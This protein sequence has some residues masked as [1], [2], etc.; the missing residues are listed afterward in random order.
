MGQVNFKVTVPQAKVCS[1]VEL[2]LGSGLGLDSSLAEVH[3]KTESGLK[4]T[5][6]VTP[7]FSFPPD[8]GLGILTMA[9][10]LT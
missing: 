3:L 8:L 1:L 4:D 10:I 6:D 9:L 5:N 7:Q 2:G